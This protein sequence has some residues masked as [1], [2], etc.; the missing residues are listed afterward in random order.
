MGVAQKT[1][2]MKVKAGFIVI[3]LSLFF[4]PQE[5][6]ASS[7][8]LP[9]PS[10]MPGNKLYSVY[11][12][13]ELFSKYWYFGDFGAIVYN[14]KFSDKYLV[15]AK[16]LFEYQQYLLAVSALKKSDYYYEQMIQALLRARKNGKNT[17]EKLV[18]VK[19]L[20]KEH[21]LLLQEMKRD[22]P[23]IFIWQPE[24]KDS[25]RLLLHE[26]LNESIKERN[27]PL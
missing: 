20:S 1:D 12:V 9:Y 25:T 26:L 24:K 7:Y 13:F 3:L 5:V 4:L 21:A 8:V 27:S 6:F 19:E 23:E 17:S 10:A 15:E 14:Q 2:S 18:I 16:T 11:K 22:M